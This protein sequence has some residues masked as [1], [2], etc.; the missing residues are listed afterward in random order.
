MLA[1]VSRRTPAVFHACAIA[2]A[3]I[4]AF[5]TIGRANIIRWDDGKTIPGT[6]DIT[7]GQDTNL[8]GRGRNLRFADL[9]TE[10]LSGSSFAGANLSHAHF[11][12]NAAT[13][14][15][16]R[17]SPPPLTDL[18]NVNFTGATIRF[19]DFSGSEGLTEEQLAFTASYLHHNLNHVDLATLDMEDWNFSRQGLFAADLASADL[20]GSQFTKSHLRKTDFSDADL[21]G[22]TGWAP[23]PTTL[24]HDTI[25]P[26]GTIHGL[27]M[28]SG[29]TLTIRNNA[30]P[31]TVD[32][33]ASFKSDSTLEFQL[34]QGWTSPVD[35]SAL[36]SG[37]G[38]LDLAFAP[39]ID[40]S[41]YFI[42]A[43]PAIGTL[44]TSSP[45]QSI[46]FQVF[47]WNSVPSSGQFSDV[48]TDPRVSWDLSNLYIN[49]TVT[50]SAAGTPAPEASTLA[51]L[52]LGGFLL[53]RR[54]QRNYR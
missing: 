15:G 3:V 7:L 47:N 30:I 41:L 10:S 40:P 8:S 33:S 11:H 19:A 18:S 43:T 54:R 13:G 2:A 51:I 14:G 46:T 28:T 22:A 6:E 34:E 16:G 12:P 24:K 26:D 31:V 5:G 32:G 49:G 1:C 9:A 53:A 36:P 4:F 37:G 17:G 52:S 23:K 35:F 42:A 45:V 27:S 38:V 39:G 44:A 48:I 20:A 50:I 21:R 25:L 29:E